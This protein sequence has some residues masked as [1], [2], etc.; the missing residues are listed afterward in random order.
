MNKSKTEF[1]I[2]N[3]EKLI[4]KAVKKVLR[5]NQVEKKNLLKPQQIRKLLC[6]LLCEIWADKPFY[7]L[8]KHRN[9]L[10]VK[11][12]NPPKQIKMSQYEALCLQ[13]WL[14]SEVQ[15]RSRYEIVDL[16]KVVQK[17]IQQIKFTQD[18]YHY[19][20]DL[21]LSSQIIYGILSEYSVLNYGK[22][23]ER[24]K[25]VQKPRLPKKIRLNLYESA[26]VEELLYDRLLNYHEDDS[27]YE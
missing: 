27:D 10:W 16:Q 8:K 20:V 13:N 17:V 4:K 5:S 7:S 22:G 11:Q 1:V 25:P 24:Q 26:L 2:L 21:M 15:I 3:T 6:K 9:E 23:L 14:T 18:K 12:G 19:S